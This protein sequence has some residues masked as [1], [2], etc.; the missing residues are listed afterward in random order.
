MPD[1]AVRSFEIQR[2][3]FSGWAILS[4]TPV[5]GWDIPHSRIPWFR[6]SIFNLKS[7]LHGEYFCGSPNRL[8]DLQPKRSV[9]GD[10][11][12]IRPNPCTKL[13]LSH[14]LGRLSGRGT[15][16]QKVKARLHSP[17]NAA[18][19]EVLQKQSGEFFVLTSDCAFSFILFLHF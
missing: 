10:I 9:S 14:C 5:R 12:V 7:I 1:V 6:C 2:I 15:V 16:V 4:G 18:K 13:R 8:P 19:F 11:A 17:S 3:S